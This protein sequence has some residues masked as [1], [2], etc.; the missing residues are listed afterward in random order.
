MRSETPGGPHRLRIILMARRG[1]TEVLQALLDHR[2]IISLLVTSQ[3]DSVT[4]PARSLAA[5]RGIPTTDDAALYRD[6]LP[7]RA[8]C[9]RD[10]DAVISHFHKRRIRPEILALA[11]IGAFNFHAAP[12]PEGGGLGVAN[13]AILECWKEYG[14]SVHWMSPEFDTGD[15][16]RVDRFP[17]EPQET[18]Q[19]LYS[20]AYA[21]TE[22]LFYWFLDLLESGRPIPRIQQGPGRYYSAKDMEAAKRILQTDS[23]EQVERRARAFWNPPFPGAYIERDGVR[24]T[25]APRCLTNP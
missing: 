13:F 25:V 9:L 7:A 17:I 10:V 19:T 6:L 18:A 4:E 14:A 3:G 23:A 11:R 16:V 20:K 24:F 21:K 22:E 15:L 8:D 1:A 12:L 2:H 5:E